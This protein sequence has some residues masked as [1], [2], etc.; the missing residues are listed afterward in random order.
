MGKRVEGGIRGEKVKNL[1]GEK[2]LRNRHV[3]GEG[4]RHFESILSGKEW[5]ESSPGEIPSLRKAQHVMPKKDYTAS[6]SHTFQGPK[7][8]DC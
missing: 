2:I 4:E 5:K 7:R 6:V 8:S 1:L 3:K